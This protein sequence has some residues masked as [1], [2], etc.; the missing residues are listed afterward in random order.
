MPTLSPEFAYIF[1]VLLA[2]STI[3]TELTNDWSST[4][5]KS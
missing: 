4:T 1:K 3:N 2:E 5:T